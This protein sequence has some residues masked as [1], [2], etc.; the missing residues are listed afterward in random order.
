MV[1][2]LACQA[3]M[4]AFGNCQI[5]RLNVDERRGGRRWRKGRSV[6]RCVGEGEGHAPWS[7][8]VPKPGCTATP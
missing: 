1:L 2:R 4:S 7:L 8:Q 5:F 3:L 6:G